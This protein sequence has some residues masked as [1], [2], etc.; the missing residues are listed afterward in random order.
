VEAGKDNKVAGV[1]AR[2]K[3]EEV[4]VP[5]HKAANHRTLVVVVVEQHKAVLE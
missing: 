1:E 4:A 3:R 5:L 2:R